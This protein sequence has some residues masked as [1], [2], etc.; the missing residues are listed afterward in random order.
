MELDLEREALFED[1]EPETAALMDWIL[2][3]PF[4]M[5]LNLHDGAVVANY[6]WDKPLN[7]TGVTLHG[8]RFRNQEEDTAIRTPDDEEFKMLSL[9]YS[10]NHGTMSSGTITC[11]GGPFKDGITNGAEWYQ[12]YGGMQDFN[13]LFTNCLE[14][15][16]E[17]S[18]IKKPPDC[19]L[20]SE[21]ENNREAML[22]FLESAGG[23]LHGVVSDSGGAGVEG[24]RIIVDG[25]DRDVFT[26]ETGE[27]WRVL[28]PGS[29]TVKAVKGEYHVLI[30]Q[31]LIS[32]SR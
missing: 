14:V 17:L 9:M 8:G 15:T 27:Y 1:R 25:R 22:T 29:Y 20:Q 30:S 3:N 26:S 6:P 10:Q 5:S 32:E 11:G 16:L 28:A 18:C 19:V 24:A 2:D 4:L 7:K 13:Y 31:I 12:I 23:V 21:W